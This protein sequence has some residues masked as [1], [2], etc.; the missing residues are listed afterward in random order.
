MTTTPQPSVRKSIALALILSIAVGAP[1]GYAAPLATGSGGAVA[2][3][4][5]QASKAAI[6][7]LDK[8]GNAIDAAVAAAAT[9]GVT[10]P[11]SCGIGGG[12]FM[13]IYLADGQRVIT[14][15]HRE[16]APAAFTPTVFLDNG[17]EIDFEQAV[18]SGASVGVPGTVRGW[19]DALERYGTMSFKQVL[20]PAIE[21]ASKGFRVS[22]NFNHLVNINVDKFKLFTTTS[23]LYLKDGKAIA[24]GATLRNPGLAQ[25]YRELGAKGYKAFYQGP[26]ARDG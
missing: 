2:T 18:A 24:V 9:L 19:H 7:I 20:A 22:E 12:G 16:S 17:K 3:I 26:I 8:G 21:V 4:S 23:A 6:D 25:A 11:F 15:D 10:D 1:L 5:A 14:L 13:V